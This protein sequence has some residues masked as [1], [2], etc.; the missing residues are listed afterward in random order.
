MPLRYYCLLKKLP[1][2]GLCLL[3]L[4]CHGQEDFRKEAR[5]FLKLLQ[6]NHYSPRTLND[7]LSEDVFKSFT[8]ALDEH[9]LYFTKADLTS[10]V[11]DKLLIDDDFKG[12]SWKVLP[13]V[14]EL[15]RKKLLFAR[16]TITDIL[17]KPIVFNSTE[18]VSFYNGIG[19]DSV[20]YSTDEAALVKRW[21]K[22]IKYKI[23]AGLYNSDSI[24]KKEP[25]VREQVKA[26]LLRSVNRI[27]EHPGGF[28][29]Y[30]ATQY[31]RSFGA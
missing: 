11:Q 17:S 1:L 26:I 23:L 16:Q 14:T 28:E 9:G 13:D 20:S 22:T 4:V 29:Q 6:A 31:L 24:V 19:K 27:L 30:V 3:S 8:E 25:E 15:Y 21:N 5:M 2:L 12:G 18:T 7:Q 10:I